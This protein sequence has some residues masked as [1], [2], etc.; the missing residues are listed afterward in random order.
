MRDEIQGSYCRVCNTHSSIILTLRGAPLHVQH[1]LRPEQIAK[2]KRID[3][4][5]CKCPECG[6]VQ[7]DE[8]PNINELYSDEYIC[9]VNFS[10]HAQ[11]YQS[12]LAERWVQQY[13]LRDKRVLEVGGGMVFSRNFSNPMAV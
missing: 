10:P 7:L 6:L 2:D 12:T 1:L 9:S 4:H 8:N 3:I 5:L 13:N 11:N